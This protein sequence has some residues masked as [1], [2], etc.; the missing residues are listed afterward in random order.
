MYL[1]DIEL[2][3]YQTN[4][5]TFPL[6]IIHN[7]TVI[8]RNSDIILATNLILICDLITVHLKYIVPSPLIAQIQLYETK[9]IVTIRN[10]R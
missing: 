6:T 7:T 2:F 10:W 4:T 5:R 1:I 8:N 3:K 9:N